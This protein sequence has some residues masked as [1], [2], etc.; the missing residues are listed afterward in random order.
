MAS[1]SI[2]NWEAKNSAVDVGK[3]QIDVTQ[4][5]VKIL[6]GRI[7]PKPWFL[8]LGQPPLLIANTPAQ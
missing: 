2:Q 8:H 3:I 5:K 6:P 7:Y 1:F 4:K